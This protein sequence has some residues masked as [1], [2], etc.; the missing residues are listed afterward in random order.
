MPPKRI[1]LATSIGGRSRC[2]Y[3]SRPSVR[4]VFVPLETFL[5]MPVA[6][7]CSECQKAAE[8]LQAD[9]DLAGVPTG[10]IIET[11]GKLP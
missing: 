10:R 11:G 9:G 7:R 1:H 6:G 3:T 4:A 2:R 5:T 8:R